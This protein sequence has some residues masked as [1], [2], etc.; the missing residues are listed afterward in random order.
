[1]QVGVMISAYDHASGIVGQIENRVKRFTVSMQDAWAAGRK[2]EAI[3]KGMRLA[4][5][6]MMALGA[7]AA[8]AL[9]IQ[10]AVREAMDAE[11]AL[12]RI[13]NI[14]EWSTDKLKAVQA[15]VLGLTSRT[16][17][18]QMS[19]LDGL[20][21]LLAKGM[22][23]DKARAL[24]L[25]IG[26]TATAASADVKDLSSALFSAVDI[27]E[28]PISEAS[29]LMDGLVTAGKEGAF[30]LKAM[31]RYLPSVLASTSALGMGG[32]LGVNQAAAWL[33]VAR[34]GAGTEEEA[35]TNFQNFL[36]KLNTPET[37]RN[38]AKVGASL[39]DELT[40][41]WESGDV[42]GTM[43]RR[44]MELSK[45]DIGKLFQDQQVLK[46]LFIAKDN[47]P[48]AQ[49]ITQRAMGAE[50]VVGKDYDRIMRSFNEQLKKA[51]I[52]IVEHLMPKVTPWLERLNGLLTW[53]GGHPKILAAGINL[54]LGLLLGGGILRFTS[55]VMG[56]YA[57][58]VR[59]GRSALDAGRY[60]AWATRMSGSFAGGLRSWATMQFPMISRLGSLTR[61]MGSL[62]V[63]TWGSVKSLASWTWAWV[64]TP[65]QTSKYLLGSLATGMQAFTIATWGTV[66]AI[67]AQTVALLAN[68]ITWV[69]VGVMA[70]VGA[71]IALWKN[72]DKVTA[73]FKGT[74]VWFQELWGKVPNWAKFF[75]PII[76]IPMFL[77]QNWRKIPEWFR[78]AWSWLTGLWNKVPGWAKLFV[79]FIGV[80]LLIVKHWGTIKAIL[81][82][83]WEWV[84]GFAGRM[85]DAGKNIV[86]NIGDGILAAI[87]SPVEAIKKVVA[88]VREF[89]PFSPAK[90]GPLT[91]IHRIKL[92]ETI[93]DSI[94]PASLVSK[95]QT[96]AGAA[97]SALGKGLAVGASV[98]VGS[99]PAMAGGSAR[100]IT[101][102]INVDARGAAPGVQQ[103]IE[104]AILKTVPAIKRELER[105]QAG[106]SRRK[107]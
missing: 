98:L 69:V 48:M 88:K 80:P 72:W 87:N 25:D 60:I 102:E 28:V 93:A 32:R 23:E 107:F 53:L 9:N 6:G 31:A 15:E 92:V 40:K 47:L 91:D 30:E 14:A 58:M 79:P 17:Q 104:R 34:K 29:K 96:V 67:W 84:K 52:L 24:L 77:I 21:D 54:I 66:K 4:G 57:P 103:D 62:T 3:G 50:G 35:A 27:A 76:S 7:T 43:V 74:W 1:M 63:A 81:G 26:R 5:D 12:Y 42:I 37:E 18:S 49:G 11:H 56:A 8:A 38:F 46:F 101:I 19:L 55:M 65:I 89:L 100:G 39:K 86:K 10:G 82:A 16:N 51:Q 68:P 85:W 71:A 70:L 45:G 44:T 97:R 73:W 99:S 20:N 64:S 94:S 13:A 22:N 95:M 90:T 59:L 78:A 61:S 36:M 2:L 106:D 105:L 41:A 83:A 75:M 33:Q